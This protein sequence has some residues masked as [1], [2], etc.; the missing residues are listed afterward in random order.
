MSILATIIA[1][2]AIAFFWRLRN[3]GARSAS[4]QIAERIGVRSDMR[5][6]SGRDLT[7][8][9]PINAIKSPLVA[10]ATLMVKTQS[11][12]FVLGDGDEEI[13]QQLLLDLAPSE[14]VDEAMHYAKWAVLEISDSDLVIDELGYFLKTQIT[15]AEKTQFVELLELA[16]RKIGGCYD[17]AASRTR[18]IKSL[19]MEVV[20]KSDG[21]SR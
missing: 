9:S 1:I 21:N 5:R 10:A 3:S 6:R 7:D 17:F 18:L 15:D 4:A 13:I 20:G 16:N 8:L 2:L 11:E 14:E 12:E 19:E